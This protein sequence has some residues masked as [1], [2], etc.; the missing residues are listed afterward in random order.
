MA[1]KDE[2]KQENIK[3][4]DMPPKKKAEYIWE[5]YK[6]PI[7]LVVAAI[8][9]IVTFARDYRINKRPYYLDAI[10]INSDIAYSGENYLLNDYIEY[11]GVDTDTYNIAI[12][13]QLILNEEKL[14]QITLANGQK[15]MALFAAGELDVVIGP[16]SIMNSYA[17]SEAFEDIDGILPDDLKKSLEDAGY[18]I[19]YATAYEDDDEGNPVPIRTYAAGVYLDKSAYLSSLEDG[20]F[21]TVTD[22]GKRPVFAIATRSARIENSLK[23]L[24][25][26]T[27]V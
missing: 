15:I 11:A 23:L 19:Y 9:F 4:K 5:Y 27:G 25:M 8:I 22:S 10:V 21:K 1:L 17:A 3:L 26:L 12:D 18:E 13:T 20:A 2:I 16:D 6:I 14:D 24:K 7:I